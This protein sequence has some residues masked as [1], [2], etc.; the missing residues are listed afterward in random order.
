MLYLLRSFKLLLIFLIIISC[1]SIDDSN[2]WVSLFNGKSLDGWEIKI[3]G[4]ELNNNHKNTFRVDDG[5]IKVT[6]EDYDLFDE[7][8]GHIFYTNKKFKNYHLK[9]DYRFYGEHVN[10]FTNEND[11][12]N[13]K[14][15]GVMLHSEHPNQMFLDQGFPVSIEGQFLGGSGVNDRPTLNMCSPGTEV[16]I[17]ETQA[18]Q[19]CVNSTSKTIHSEEW[20]SVEFLVYSDSIVHHIID[21]DTV[22]SYSN[23]RYG[24]TYLSENFIDKVG[25]PLK[26]GYISLQSEGHPIE[27]KNIRVKELD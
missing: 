25:D 8:F 10:L 23:I 22:M 17:N 7:N 4:Y 18:M 27:F 6:Y 26:E 9:L 5:T 1:E 14:N 21:K 2:K 13:Y 15:S 20:V 11:A 12:W 3:S 24:G 19:H 16:D